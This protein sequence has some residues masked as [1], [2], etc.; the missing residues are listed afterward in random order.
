MVFRQLPL[1]VQH[2]DFDPAS[3]LLS[4]LAAKNGVHSVQQFCRDIAF[5]IEPLFRGEPVAVQQLAQLAGCDVAGLERVSIRYLGR[6]HF[7]LR[8]EIVTTHTLH[9]SRVR[10]CPECVRRDVP[11]AVEAWR[12]PRRLQW[13]FVSVRTCPEHGCMLL[14]LPPEKFTK[15]GKDFT[16]QIRK[17]FDWI[18]S[19]RSI[20]NEHSAFECY[21]IERVLQG[22]GDDWIDSLE[23]NVASRACEVLGLL[24]TKGAEAKLSGHTEK[25]WAIYG[26]VGYEI[27]KEG[28]EA[29]S[30]CLCDLET[31]EGGD[32][33]FF[34]KIYGPFIT[35]LRGRGLGE[36]FEPLR[37]VV[38]RQIFASFP[39]RKGILVLGV[40]SAGITASNAAA[41]LPEAEYIRENG[42]LLVQRGL[43]QQDDLGHV[44]L[45]GFVTEG[46]LK[47]FVRER[48]ADTQTMRHGNVCRA[49]LGSVVK[50][51]LSRSSSAETMSVPEAV[52]F[53]HVTA[54]TVSYLAEHRFLERAEAA[55]GYRTGSLVL[56]ASSLRVFC[57]RYVSLGELVEVSQCPQGALVMK[58]RNSGLDMLAMPPD[59]SRIFWREDINFSEL[60]SG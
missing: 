16:V 23:L 45:K 52:C 5:P 46:M 2:A 19:Q 42:R 6:G 60:K 32:H 12:L 44:N 27:L 43:A 13:K 14:S 41:V 30:L 15:D 47:S 49:P 10:V 37:D 17:H 11:A 59:F 33:R 40:P 51:G 26:A 39:V 3:S 8:E 1:M 58:L 20:P 21:L 53:L 28:A 31:H 7:R 36:E 48:L 57:A 34:A 38:R 22:R 50:T 35:W 56:R 54:K 18:L 24:L 4:R 25:D 29:L 55:V 9:R